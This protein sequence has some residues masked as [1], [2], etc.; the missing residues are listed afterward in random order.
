MAVTLRSGV[1]RV[2]IPLVVC[3]GLFARGGIRGLLAQ[4][5]LWPPYL[6]LSLSLSLSLLCC[7]HNEEKLVTCYVTLHRTATATAAAM[8]T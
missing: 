2:D 1:D 7:M 3:R 6:L 5:Q 8:S 4:T